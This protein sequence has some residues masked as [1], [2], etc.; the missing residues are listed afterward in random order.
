[1]NKLRSISLKA[2]AVRAAA[3]LGFLA[4][5][6]LNATALMP[7]SSPPVGSKIRQEIL[8]VVR[9]RLEAEAQVKVKLD[10]KEVLVFG[11]VAHVCVVPINIDGSPL[12]M[13][14]S[15]L[16]Q[17]YQDMID[18]EADGIET[19]LEGSASKLVKSNG[20]WFE[21]EWNGGRS[22]CDK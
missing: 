20:R 9:V 15:I 8:D 16:S 1:M 7:M 6:S 5:L 18:G 12:D 3:S 17:V 13:K 2:F 10:V 19:G 22:V 14:K 21:V 11:G 4:Y